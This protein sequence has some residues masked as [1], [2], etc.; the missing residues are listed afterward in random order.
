MLGCPH[1]S[2]DQVEEVARLVEGKKFKDGVTDL[3]RDTTEGIR[4]GDWVRVDGDRGTAEV[5]RRREL[6]IKTRKSGKKRAAQPGRPLFAAVPDAP[7]GA[8]FLTAPHRR[9]DGPCSTCWPR[10]GA[11]GTGRPAPGRIRPGSRCI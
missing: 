8:A 4:T 11:A 7:S 1:Y 6:A 5:L 10:S 3:D 2:I 9:T